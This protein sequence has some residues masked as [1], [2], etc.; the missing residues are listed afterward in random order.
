MRH[1]P[2]HEVSCDEGGLVQQVVADNKKMNCLYF[3]RRETISS[4]IADSDRGSECNTRGICIRHI[5]SLIILMTSLFAIVGSCLGDETDQGWK[6]AGIRGGFSATA[7]REYFHTYEVY[8]EYGLPWAL[9]WGL[10]PQLNAAA[11]VL[12]GG[13]DNGF[14]GSI[15]ADVALKNPWNGLEADLGINVNLIDKRRFG[16]QDFGSMLLFGAYAGLTY[17]IY[18]GLGINYRLLHLSNGH[19]FYATDT[20]NPGLDLHMFGLTWRF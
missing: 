10:Y 6:E 19:I 14:I 18:R 7:K 8:A 3:R 5:C 9:R 2:C 16:K 12:S 1:H 4:S 15:G 11:G 17:R 13:G 20:P